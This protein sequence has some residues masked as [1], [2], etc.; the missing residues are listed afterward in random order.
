LC[1]QAPKVSAVAAR[2]DTT[3]ARV[4]EMVRLGLFESVSGV[5]VKLGRNIR[6]DPEKLEVWIAKG[7][8]ALPGGWRQ[9]AA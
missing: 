7:G 8:Q 9:E 2:V 3:E 6:F 1:S 5:V 4:Y